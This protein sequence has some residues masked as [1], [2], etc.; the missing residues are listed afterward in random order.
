MPTT[1]HKIP[2]RPVGSSANSD[3]AIATS[4][5]EPSQAQKVKPRFGKL[6]NRTLSTRVLDDGGRRSKPTTPTTPSRT[7]APEIQLQSEGPN[8]YQSTNNAAPLTAPL[9]QDRSLRDMMNSDS[10]NRSADRHPRDGDSQE[11][12]GPRRVGPPM[13]SS[14]SAAFREN[15]GSH[16]LTNIKTTG[17]RAA[18]GLGRASRDIF[19]R[20]GHRKDS[21]TAKEED[22][23]AFYVINLPLV[24]QTRKTRIASRLEDSKDKTEFW[25]PALPWR[26]IE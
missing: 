16:L 2:R 20:V 8:E 22:R 14:T 5:L 11:N 25:M 15:A 4:P 3:S 12:V 18:G 23:N 10:R 17:S 19:H 13:T 7:T 9:R 6:L 26:C 1:V 21:N 24:E